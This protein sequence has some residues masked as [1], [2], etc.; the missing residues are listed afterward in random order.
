MF[1]CVAFTKDGQRLV[2]VGKDF[3]EVAEKLKKF[4]ITEFVGKEIRLTD[5]RQ[6]K[7]KLNCG[8]R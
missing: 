1:E 3:F 7:E 8:E 5:L 4:N 6:G 2:F